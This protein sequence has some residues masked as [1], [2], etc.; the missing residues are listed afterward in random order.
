M[1]T[2]GSKTPAEVAAVRRD[3]EIERTNRA[4][5]DKAQSKIKLLLLGTGES[6]KSTIVKQM[7]LIYGSGF[8]ESDKRS[9]IP[10]VY[11]NT[12]SSM[13]ALI[14]AAHELGYPIH[15]TAAAALVT[16]AADDSRLDG[17]VGIA[18]R[19]LWTD[20]GIQSAFAQRHRFQLNDS[21]EYFFVA[22]PRTS[23]PDYVP[24][25]E[26]ILRTRVKTTGIV[27][28][29]FLIEG[30]EFVVYDAG[31][32]RNERRKW[33]HCFDDVTAIIFVVAISEYDQVLFEDSSVNRLLEAL[34]LFENV[35]NS[36]YFANTPV[37]IFFNKSDIFLDK[38]QRIDLRQRNPDTFGAETEPILFSDYAGGC[39]YTL[40]INYIVNRFLA[41]NRNPK[42]EIFYHVTCATDTSQVA[43]V[44]SAV[45]KTILSTNL[46]QSGF[47][48]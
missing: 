22:L 16:S 35:V 32:Q 30:T 36:R 8:S 43:T 17:E 34:R 28:E 46:R 38:I 1:G 45:K 31:G 37:I 14:L 18:V 33:I 39:N 13:K 21:A 12:V 4:A 15:T 25:V 44:L 11:N 29:Q 7:K 10:V 20:S 3:L 19:A 26:D 23:L 42:K 9:M 48:G 5:F 40:A 6:G 2:C 41:L 24:T 47:E 27:T